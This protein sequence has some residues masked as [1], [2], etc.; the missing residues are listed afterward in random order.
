MAAAPGAR[1]GKRFG[2]GRGIRT[3]GGSDTTAVFKTGPEVS[4]SAAQGRRELG[5]NGGG[6]AGYRCVLVGS[7][8]NWGM[9]WGTG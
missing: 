7:V 3:P 5:R 2:G 9:N 6:A 4:K 8:A 1:M